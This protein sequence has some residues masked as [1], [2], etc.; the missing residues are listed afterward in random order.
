MI[1]SIQHKAMADQITTVSKKRITNQMSALSRADMQAV[2]RTIKFNSD[3]HKRV[4]LPG[5]KRV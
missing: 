5:A 4:T 1:N 2:E 3:S